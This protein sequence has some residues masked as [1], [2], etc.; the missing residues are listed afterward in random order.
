M[1]DLL[2]RLAAAFSL[3]GDVRNFSLEKSIESNFNL[4]EIITG[5]SLALLQLKLKYL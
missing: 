5:A 3:Y 1:T 4:N 2:T